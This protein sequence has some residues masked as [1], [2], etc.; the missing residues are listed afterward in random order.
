MTAKQPEVGTY[1]LIRDVAN[2]NVDRRRTIGW[3]AS[4]RWQK[5]MTFFIRE[6]LMVMPAGVPHRTVLRLRVTG[7][8]T[9]LALTDERCGLLLANATRLDDTPSLWLERAEVGANSAPQILDKLVATGKVTDADVR[10]AY[11]LVLDDRKGE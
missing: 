3:S 7:A 5:G 11:E 1:R 2:P 10:A 9:S 6:E 4:T 8:I